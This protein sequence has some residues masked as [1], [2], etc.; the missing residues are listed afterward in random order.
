MILDRAQTLGLHRLGSAEEDEKLWS[1]ERALKEREGQ[2]NQSPNR[3][4]DSPQTLQEALQNSIS[5]GTGLFISKGKGKVKLHPFE[6]SEEFGAYSHPLRE[7]GRR[8]YT[9]ICSLE[10]FLC[11]NASAPSAIRA[12]DSGVTTSLPLNIEDEDLEK[13][14]LRPQDRNV[15]TPL[16]F[17]PIYTQISLTI[18]R[19]S[20]AINRG[21]GYRSVLAMHGELKAILDDLPFFF[22]YDNE[23]GMSE[24]TEEEIVERETRNEW[25]EKMPILRF[26][27]CLIHHFVNWR[28]LSLHRMYMVSLHKRQK[29]QNCKHDFSKT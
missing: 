7:T 8:V 25:F 6:N 14:P 26:Q 24:E 15:P 20:E 27:R 10:W 12:G 16:S 4:T 1:E 13:S 23:N 21:D 2:S 17:L 29:V 11:T 28:F 22:R 3:E 9:L 5:N 19:I 18:A